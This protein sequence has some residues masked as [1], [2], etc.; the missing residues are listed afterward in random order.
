[1]KSSTVIKYLKKHKN[2]IL[3]HVEKE[4]EVTK[5]ELEMDL[6]EIEI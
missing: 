4:I 1:M 6:D 2:D 5:E 3:S